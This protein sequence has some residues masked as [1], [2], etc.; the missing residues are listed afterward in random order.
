MISAQEK[1]RQNLFNAAPAVVS[2]ISF[3]FVLFLIAE[4]WI[5]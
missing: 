4:G 5:W 1:M 2:V 3:T